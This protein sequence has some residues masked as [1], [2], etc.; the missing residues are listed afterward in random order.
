VLYTLLALAGDLLF[1]LALG[2]MA[3]ASR[4]AW[5]RIDPSTSVPLVTR[6][7]ETLVGAPRAIALTLLPAVA[8]LIGLGLLYAGAEA[9]GALEPAI[10]V[11]GLKATLSALFALAHLRLVARVIRALGARGLLRS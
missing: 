10:I 9:R 11:F 6:S 8:F 3:G 1:V 2:I 4:Q 5:R 7:G